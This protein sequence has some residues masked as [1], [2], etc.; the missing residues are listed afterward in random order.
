[1]IPTKKSG[2]WCKGYIVPLGLGMACRVA[3]RSGVARGRHLES[4]EKDPL[5]TNGSMT[6]HSLG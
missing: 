2:H 3:P 6:N 1:M 5:N 4:P